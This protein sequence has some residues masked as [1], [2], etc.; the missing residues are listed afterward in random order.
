MEPDLHEL[1]IELMCKHN[2]PGVATYLKVADGYRL[3]ETLEVR[4]L[5]KWFCGR[6]LDL[7]GCGSRSDLGVAL[8]RFSLAGNQIEDRCEKFFVPD[9]LGGR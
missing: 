2:P 7:C 1:Y 6:R 4:L 9:S 8:E 5:L 3:E